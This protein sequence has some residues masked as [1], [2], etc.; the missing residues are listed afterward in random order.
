MSEK[1]PAF[2]SQKFQ[3]INLK[4]NKIQLTNIVKVLKNIKNYDNTIQITRNSLV[5]SLI[6]AAMDND[7]KILELDK[8]G[9]TFKELY[10]LPNNGKKV[11][12]N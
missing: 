4:L 8:V 11:N 5:F 7:I 12:E 10:D 3:N 2:E 6:K 9:Y 1:L